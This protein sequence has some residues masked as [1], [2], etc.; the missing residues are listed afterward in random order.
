MK[1]VLL[2]LVFSAL[3]LF[4]M[5]GIV[6]EGLVL[7][8]EAGSPGYNPDFKWQPVAGS[9][10]ILT[11]ARDRNYLLP[12]LMA[13]DATPLDPNDS[14]YNCF[15]NFR[16][17]NGTTSSQVV[18]FDPSLMFDW[19]DSFTL[20]AWIRPLHENGS[21]QKSMIFGSRSY[22]TYGTWWSPNC[23]GYEFYWQSDGLN[24]QGRFGLVF[25]DQIDPGQNALYMH[26]SIYPNNQWHHVVIIYDGTNID[27]EGNPTRSIYVNGIED[28]G[29]GRWGTLTPEGQRNYVPEGNTLAM[30]SRYNRQD[31]DVFADWAMDYS[32]FDIAAFRVYNKVLNSSEI[33]Q[34][35]SEGISVVNKVP[36]KAINNTRKVVLD[37]NAYPGLPMA[38][39]GPALNHIS[40]EK[41]SK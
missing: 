2:V 34:N 10:G 19:D 17:T 3:P 23:Q 38:A 27:T 41:S 5:A 1:K 16:T 24:P 21:S 20:E 36:E 13:E 29:I 4:C 35:Y 40:M 33:G 39:S 14:V 15:Y 6:T 32:N 26:S 18:G 22:V 31:L 37:L 8:L 28:A 25:E 12:R 11:D 30:G 7:D 9:G